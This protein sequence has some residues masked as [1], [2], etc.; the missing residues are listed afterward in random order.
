MTRLDKMYKALREH[1]ESIQN[2]G[3]KSYYIRKCDELSGLIAKEEKR[4][5]D[6]K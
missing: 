2:G 3:R 6:S 1:R 4:L 5:V